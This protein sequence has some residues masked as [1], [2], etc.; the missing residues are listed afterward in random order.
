MFIR[1]WTFQVT[2]GKENEFEQIY[3]PDGDWAKLFRKSLGYLKTE[4]HRDTN[5][6]TRYLT[7]DYFRSKFE[8]KNFLTQFKDEYAALDRRCE[9]LTLSEQNVGDFEDMK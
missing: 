9:G 3:G 6:H 5:D 7:T 8:F 4:L 1:I 2:P